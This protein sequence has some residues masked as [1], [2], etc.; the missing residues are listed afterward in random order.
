MALIRNEKPESQALAPTSSAS[1][2]PFRMMRDLM[3]WDPF[4]TMPMIS[5]AM[6]APMQEAFAPAFDV[7]ETKD[8]YRI[9]ADLPGVKES[10]LDLKVTGNRLTITGSRDDEREDKTDAYYTY[11]RNFGSFQRS[12]GLPDGADT[13]H[14]HA[15]LKAGV[16][17]IAIPKKAGEQTKTIAVK[18]DDK[19]S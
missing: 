6:F 10:D 14:V 18:T 1:I 15:E 12:F 19:K 13:N 4:G 2:D 17:T 11:E 16:L 8:S 5:P 7:K 3:R 9:T